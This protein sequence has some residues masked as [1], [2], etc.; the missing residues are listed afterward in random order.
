[1]YPDAGLEKLLGLVESLSKKISAID[2]AGFLDASVLGETV[3]PRN[4]NTLHRIENEDGT[5]FEE[6]EQFT[7]LL[8]N[9]F[10]L[11]QLRNLLNAGGRE[12][13]NQLPDGIHSGLSKPRAKGIFF[14]FKAKV[15]GEG[16]PYHFWKYYD[17]NTGEI[18]D[19]RFLIT[20]LISCSN[21]TPR[22]IGD[23]DVFDI[24]EKVIN[25]IIDTQ[26]KVLALAVTPKT[27]DPI[28]QTVATL[29][30]G[31]LNSPKVSRRKVVEAIKYIN[32]PLSGVQVRELK[33]IHQQYQETHDLGI[34]IQ[35][36]NKLVE[37]YGSQQSPSNSTVKQLKREDLKLICFD[38][39]CS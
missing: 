8:S 26:E 15:E 38:Y 28:Q 22:V 25:S 16:N 7:E 17:I 31:H 9:E 3:H 5:V 19:N 12:M 13:L 29:L 6:E 32:Q 11:Q 14:Y 30:Q 36:I 18:I 37:T 35:G 4:F 34:L 20:N 10:L 2:R 21:D 24:Q 39:L 1:M 27:I 33:N 23:S